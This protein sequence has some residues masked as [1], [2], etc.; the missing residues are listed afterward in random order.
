MMMKRNP[1]TPN[2]EQNKD[3][4]TPKKRRLSEQQQREFIEFSK[5][6]LAI[7][8]ATSSSTRNFNCLIFFIDRHRMCVSIE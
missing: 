8:F 2:S 3:T 6:F 1:E 5:D 4:N 7:S